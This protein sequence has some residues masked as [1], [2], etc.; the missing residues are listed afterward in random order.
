MP[1]EAT[2]DGRQS[3]VN[4]RLST[5]SAQARLDIDEV[6]L[7]PQMNFLYQINQLTKRPCFA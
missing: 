1:A 6:G 7:N 5:A 2:G 4:S 3:R